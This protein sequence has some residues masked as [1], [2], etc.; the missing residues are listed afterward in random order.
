MLLL[1]ITYATTIP[2]GIPLWVLGDCTREQQNSYYATRIGMPPDTS[3]NFQPPT[4]TDSLTSSVIG[5]YGVGTL[6]AKWLFIL[7][8][9]SA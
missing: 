6:W 8:Q 2:H 1:L 5:H 3:P 9:T 7:A 4:P